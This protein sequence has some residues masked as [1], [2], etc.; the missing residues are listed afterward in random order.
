MF[1]II[2][3]WYSYKYKMEPLC[4]SYTDFAFAGSDMTCTDRL[5][6]QASVEESNLTRWLRESILL[7]LDRRGI[8]VFK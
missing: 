2:N 5:E 6:T 8:S 7:F 1:S 3:T 4:S